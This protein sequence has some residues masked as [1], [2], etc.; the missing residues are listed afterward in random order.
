MLEDDG[1]ATLR[2]IQVLIC[3]QTSIICHYWCGSQCARVSCL[4]LIPGAA[5]DI[6]APV[7]CLVCAEEFS[8][9]LVPLPW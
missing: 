6:G 5:L 3:H 4:Y 2:D 1:A 7:R 9:G 8:M